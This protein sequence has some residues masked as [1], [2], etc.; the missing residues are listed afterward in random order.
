MPA[1]I[2]HSSFPQPSDINC[3]L[4][5]YMDF[6]KF[7][8]M[9]SSQTL[10]LSRSD[11]FNDPFEGS[12]SEFNIKN[13]EFV[14]KD[15]TPEQYKIM[16]EQLFNANKLFRKLTF[17]NC[18]HM[19]KYESAA[20]WDLYSKTNESIA[21][22]TSYLELINVLPNNCYL[23]V[24]NYVDYTN[25]FIPENNSFSPFMYKR[26]SF[27]HEKEVRILNQDLSKI[28]TLPSELEK[29]EGIKV[30]V[31]MHK[32]I[33]KIHVSP[34]STTWFYNLVKEITEKYEIRVEVKKSD[35]Y[36]PLIY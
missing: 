14:Y 4:W 7:V 2:K 10:H 33:K 35:L 19:N 12:F 30:E 31:N 36:N 23:G 25:T 8:A 34:N 21:I 15:M 26:K 18:W 11:K 5:R 22:E 17:I 6:T 29:I 24:V 28:G 1:V 3:Q 9:I 16:T 27:E 32:L 20:M 13:R